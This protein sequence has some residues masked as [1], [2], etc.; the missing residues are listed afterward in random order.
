[1]NKKILIVDDSK[2][3]RINLKNILTKHN[4]N[5]FEAENGIEGVKKAFEVL[6]DLIISDVVMPE[7]NGYGLSYL[8]THNNYTKHIPI[9]ILTS[10]DKR[11]DKFWGLKSGAERFL[12]K[13]VSEQ[14]IINAV[15]ELLER[16]SDQSI[17]EISLKR[18]KKINPQSFMLELFDEILKETVLAEEIYRLHSF[19]GD[20]TTFLSKMFN[21]FDLIF[22]FSVAGIYKESFKDKIL[23]L[24]VSKNCSSKIKEYIKSK[25]IK[26]TEN[27]NIFKELIIKGVNLNLI[28]ATSDYI[29]ENCTEFYYQFEN[30]YKYGVIIFHKSK[31]KYSVVEKLLQHGFEMLFNVNRLIDKAVM[32]SI[33]DGLTGA[34]NRRYLEDILKK[35][36]D[37]YLRYH[38]IFSIIMMDIDHFKKVNDTYGHQAGDEC[39][40]HLV[41]VVKN[42]IRTSDIIA[43]YGGEE[44]CV[45]CYEAEKD[46]AIYLA[47]RIRNKIKNSEIKFQDKVIKFTVSFGVSTVNKTM[48]NHEDLIKKADNALYR[49]KNSG[50]DRVEFED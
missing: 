18:L 29:P 28:T 34:F 32:L 25:I 13:G 5:V 36:F 16:K 37:K 15:N 43:R 39:L 14:E 41:N 9:I 1:M 2:T 45:V 42:S 30:Q 27:K 48:R 22:D 31:I 3:Q 23:Y 21:F 4:F 10:Q 19:V 35:D 38:Y 7:M 8:L 6:P 26:F 12:I 46:D 11:I 40:K 20:E 49:A 24:K 47:E 50:R 33:I 44:F 17:D